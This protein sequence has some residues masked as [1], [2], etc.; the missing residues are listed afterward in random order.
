MTRVL[1]IDNEVF[2]AEIVQQIRAGKRVVMTA[3]GNSMR[4]FITDLKD[5][6]ILSPFVKEDLQI[7]QSVLARCTDGRIVLHRIVKR[8]GDVL[9]LRGDGNWNQWETT[10]IHDVE[11]LLYG[12][13]RKNKTYLCSGKTW[14]FYS[15]CWTTLAPLRRWLLAVDSRILRR[16]GI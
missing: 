7:G 12:I 11:A 9:T 15:W 5:K 2:F 3:R 6:L 4:P 1:Y 10:T 16:L 13:I 8:E 14:R